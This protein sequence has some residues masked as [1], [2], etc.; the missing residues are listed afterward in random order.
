M[1]IISGRYAGH[2]GLAGSNVFQKTLDYPDYTRLRKGAKGVPVV[3]AHPPS[4]M[5][6]GP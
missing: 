5:T 2:H 6:T 3:A 1:T 4:Q